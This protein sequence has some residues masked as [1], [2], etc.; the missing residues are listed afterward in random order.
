MSFTTADLYDEF[1]DRLQVVLPLFRDFGGKRAFHGPVSTVKVH[2]DNSL[3]RA[4]LEEPGEGRVLVVDGGES[5]RCAL[6]GDML[7]KLGMDNGWTGI[8]VSGCIRDSAEIASMDIGVKAIG[9]NP[10]KSVKKGAG[11]RDIP[12]CFA[13][14]E[15]RPGHFLYADED[16]ILVSEEKL[17]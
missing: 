13:G 4:A 10:R 7:A 3:V 17:T 5:L 6:L 16:G 12:V 2:E 1:G 9:T 8:V 15:F 14:V 11:D